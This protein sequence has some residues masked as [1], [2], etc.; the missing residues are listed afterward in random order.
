[1][2]NTWSVQYHQVGTPPDHTVHVLIE[3][4]DDVTP[5]TIVEELAA[6]HAMVI[7]MIKVPSHSHKG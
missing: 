2:T 1:M 5:V 4:E 6:A 7:W 3:T